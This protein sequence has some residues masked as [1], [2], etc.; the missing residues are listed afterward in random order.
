MMNPRT[1]AAVASVLILA[2]APAAEWQEIAT[3]SI[4]PEEPGYGGLCGIVVDAATGRVS[5]MLSD[6]GVFRSDDQGESWARATIAPLKGRTESPGCWLIDPTGK[7][8]RMVAA[9][10][11][12]APIAASDDGGASF[13]HL[14]GASEHIDWCAVDWTRPEPGFVLALKHEK[15]GLLIASTDGGKSFEEIGTGY[16]SGWVFDGATAVVAKEIGGDDGGPTLQRTTDG[17]TT[18]VA[19][20]NFTPVGRAS[21]RALPV[22][23]DS[24]LYWLTDAGLITTG[25]RGATWAIVSPVAGALYG[26]VFGQSAEHLFVLTT[27]GIIESHDGGK[28]WADPVA[29]PDG[30]GGV[31]GLTWLDYDPRHDVLYLMKMGSDLYRLRR[32]G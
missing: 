15:D 9:L 32:E 30:L 29:I 14:D 20:G 7:S 16:I 24:A 25:D 17:G 19:C 4:T 23:R 31:V 3:T 27:Q 26:P 28:S 2:S 12:G 18:F 13:R 1:F 8:G 11:Y 5:V 6:L 21:A 22:W 10:V